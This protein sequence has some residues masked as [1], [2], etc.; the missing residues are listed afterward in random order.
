M[1]GDGCRPF[2]LKR[3]HPPGFIEIGGHP[4]DKVRDLMVQAMWAEI[5]PGERQPLPAGVADI[6]SDQGAASQSNALV[7]T[8]LLVALHVSKLDS[9]RAVPTS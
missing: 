8:L 6:P 5:S 1:I 4:L 3:R 9:G 7:L 2:E